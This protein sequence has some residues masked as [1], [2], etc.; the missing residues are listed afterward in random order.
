MSSGTIEEKIYQR[1]ALHEFPNFFMFRQIFKQ[2]LANRVLVDPKQ[3]RFFKTN[4]LHEL[5]TLADER[6]DKAHGT[7]TAA[8]FSSTAEEVNKRNLFDKLQK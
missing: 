2:F 1:F 6:S 8:I 3:R 5:F 7:E 4:D